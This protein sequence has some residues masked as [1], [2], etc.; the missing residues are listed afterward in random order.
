MALMDIFRSAVRPTTTESTPASVAANPTVPDPGSK[1]N[2]GSVAAF[3]VISKEPDKNPLDAYADL[4][5]VDTKNVPGAGHEPSMVPQLTVEP[6]KIMEVARTIDFTKGIAPELLDKAVKGDAESLV[7]LINSA[8][9]NAYAQG[10][11][12]TT[13]I[14]KNAFTIQDQN[15][16][17]TVMPS[18]LRRH[19]INSEVQKVS[20]ADNPA[21]APMLQI[22]EQQFATKY[23]TASPT[24]IREHA[25]QYL[26]GFA[27]EIVRGQGGTIIPKDNSN[28]NPFGVPARKEEDW[29][30]FFGV[31]DQTMN[32]GN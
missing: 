7:T 14:V 24:E 11:M 23:P 9:Q 20:I 12:A 4:W 13:S 16:K 22:L 26:S 30:R 27:A 18:V 19:S 21:A 28:G 1:Q 6:T 29:E 5:K 10:A 25:E 3:P 31:S 15:F 2:D 8:A 32:S 17:Q